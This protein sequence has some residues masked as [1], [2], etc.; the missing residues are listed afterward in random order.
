VSGRSLLGFWFCPCLQEH[1]VTSNL[2]DRIAEHS[3]KWQCDRTARETTT[4]PFVVTAAMS[5]QSG[6]ARGGIIAGRGGP[7]TLLN[8]Q[9]TSQRLPAKRT[10]Q[11]ALIAPRAPGHS[12][13]SI[14]RR[15]GGPDEPSTG[16][17]K[18][19]RAEF[20][21]TP[22]PPRSFCFAHYSG[23]ANSP[24]P[25]AYLGKWCSLSWSCQQDVPKSFLYAA[26]PMPSAGTIAP[27]K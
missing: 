3:M 18:I 13:Q 9:G 5:W 16:N 14:Q 17:R 23:D 8:S 20:S 21:P 6:T 27:C 25:S 15:A 10:Q 1:Q 22:T 12:A 7:E 4:R 11:N 2:S 19:G 24:A 26:A